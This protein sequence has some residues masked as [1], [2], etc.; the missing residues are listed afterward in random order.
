MGTGKTHIHNIYGKLDVSSR[1][2]AIARASHLGLLH[3]LSSYE[4]P[5][6]V[7]EENIENPFKELRAFQEDDAGDFFGRDALIERLLL[8]LQED[9]PLHRFLAVVGPSGSGKSS[10]VKA[11]LLY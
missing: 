10:V 9:S 2:Q 11:G 7:D 1:T 5:A 6:T 3:D 4:L 8:R